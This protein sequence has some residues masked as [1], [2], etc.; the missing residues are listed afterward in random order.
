MRIRTLAIA[1]AMLALAFAGSLVY[2]RVREC[3]NEALAYAK[4]EQGYH[5]LGAEFR[6][7]LRDAADGQAKVGG[8]ETAPSADQ[9]ISA[10]LKERRATLRRC[11]TMADNLRDRFARMR[12]QCEAAARSPWAPHPQLPDTETQQSELAA[13]ARDA[14][15]MLIAATRLKSH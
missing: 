10:L 2:R 4:L 15:D 14:N 1:V 11:A 5:A 3:S 6:I 7:G 12:Q 13:L 9:E 8:N